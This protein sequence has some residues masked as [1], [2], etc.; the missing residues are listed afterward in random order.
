MYYRVQPEHVAVL[1]PLVM[2]MH[3]SLA[4]AFPGLVTRLWQRTDLV[5]G[6]AKGTP[7]LTWMETCEHPDGVSPVCVQALAQAAADLVPHGMGERHVEVFSP[8]S[9]RSAA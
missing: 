5:Q 1:Q 4:H 2:A 9:A 7:A 3:A 6:D 8:L